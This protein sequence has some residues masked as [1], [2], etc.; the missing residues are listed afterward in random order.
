MK[1]KDYALGRSSAVGTSLLGRRDR[2]CILL[3][4]DVGALFLRMLFMHAL[5]QIEK[6]ELLERFIHLHY[7][8][9]SITG[10]MLSYLVDQDGKPLFGPWVDR[11]K[12]DDGKSTRA[13]RS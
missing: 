4:Q 12:S 2:P 5:T 13:Y 9:P 8:D 1:P 10:R 6:D 3:L 7:A 11:S